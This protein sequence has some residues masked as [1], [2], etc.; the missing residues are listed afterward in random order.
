MC[1]YLEIDTH[2]HT[3]THMYSKHRDR[4]CLAHRVY[5]VSISSAF[6]EVNRAWELVGIYKPGDQCSPFELWVGHR[7]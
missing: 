1:V 7:C 5:R 6:M 2:L 4:H 3:H